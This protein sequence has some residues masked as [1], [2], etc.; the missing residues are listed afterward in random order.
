MH[1]ENV[2]YAYSGILFSIKKTLILLFAKTW[3]NVKHFAK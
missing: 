3:I 2:V 1:K